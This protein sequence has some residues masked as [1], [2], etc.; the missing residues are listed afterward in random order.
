MHEQATLKA[1]NQ[2]RQ[3]AP[4]PGTAPEAYCFKCGAPLRAGSLFCAHCG[5]SIGEETGTQQNK[6]ADCTSPQPGNTPTPAVETT[7]ED[8]LKEP[9]VTD[10]EPGEP[11]ARGCSVCQEALPPS[12][13]Y[14]LACGAATVPQ[15]PQLVLMRLGDGGPTKVAA[16]DKDDVLIGKS[17]QCQVSLSNDGYA[18]RRH[19]RVSRAGEQLVVEDLGSS[20]GTFV[21][22]RRPFALDVGDEILIGSTA[23]RVEQIS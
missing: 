20:N 12:A 9:T 22:V 14:C 1:S 18:S 4:A 6:A 7:R 19:A 16:L 11:V 3:P 2:S 23:F 13:R 17:D 5:C 8:A 15:A 10:P 21:R